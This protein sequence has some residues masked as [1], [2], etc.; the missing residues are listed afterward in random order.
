MAYTLVKNPS[1]QKL[2]ASNIQL[3]QTS[4]EIDKKRVFSLEQTIRSLSQ[5]YSEEE[6]TFDDVIAKK[7]ELEK[8]DIGTELYAPQGEEEVVSGEN[9][10]QMVE[11]DEKEVVGDESG[12]SDVPY[13]RWS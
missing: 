4:A 2:T 9:V 7:A 1:L 10:M 3:L 6:V 11:T 5:D 8:V 13:Q 12:K